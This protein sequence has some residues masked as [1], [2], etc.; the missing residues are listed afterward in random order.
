MTVAGMR[1]GRGNSALEI[2]TCAELVSYEEYFLSVGDKTG[3][4]SIATGH[5]YKCGK[6]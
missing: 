4:M 3:T 2:L 1:R 5:G 6:G